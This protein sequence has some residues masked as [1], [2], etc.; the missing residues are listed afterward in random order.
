[1]TTSNEKKSPKS[2]KIDNLQHNFNP[3]MLKLEYGRICKRYD[4]LCNSYRELEKS[5]EKECLKT[6]DLRLELVSLKSTEFVLSD[7]KTTQT[8]SDDPDDL[9]WAIEQGI[10]IISTDKFYEIG[11][12]ET[13]KIIKDVLGD[14]PTYFTF[15]IDGIDPT[16]APGTGTPEV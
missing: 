10:T 11:L 5:Y 15:D 14:T 16:F 3:K 4:I 13:I 7:K 9:K 6:D 8:D 2:P 12:K 1:M